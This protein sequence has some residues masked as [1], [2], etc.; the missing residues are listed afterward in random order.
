MQ[1]EAE[2][3]PRAQGWQRRSLA[4]SWESLYIPD[5]VALERNL[6]L[7]K[8]TYDKNFS[9]ATYSNQQET[10]E[11]KGAVYQRGNINSKRGW[12]L[13]LQNHKQVI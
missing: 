12:D 2:D 1:K 9:P 7:F 3:S 10:H 13:S 4:P 6:Q 11:K 8:N 5:S